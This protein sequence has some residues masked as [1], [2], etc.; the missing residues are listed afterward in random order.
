MLNITLIFQQAHGHSFLFLGVSGALW[1]LAIF[2]ME[3]GNHFV[4]RLRG[5][6]LSLMYMTTVVSTPNCGMFSVTS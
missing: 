1:H 6:S 5:V 2:W 3:R 4:K